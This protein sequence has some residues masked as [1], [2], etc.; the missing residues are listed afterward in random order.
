MFS[1]ED[2]VHDGVDSALQLALLELQ[3]ALRLFK[4][5]FDFNLFAGGIIDREK[6]AFEMHIAEGFFEALAVSFLKVEEE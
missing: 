3:V 6:N 2:L 4:G 5:V 1:L